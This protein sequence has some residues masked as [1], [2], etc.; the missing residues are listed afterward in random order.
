MQNLKKEMLVHVECQ[1]LDRK[2]EF[3]LHVIT[4]NLFKEDKNE[5]CK[6][7]FAHRCGVCHTFRYLS[8]RVKEYEN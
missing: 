5:V 4:I 2:N 6:K 8:Q 7:K 1:I 3:D